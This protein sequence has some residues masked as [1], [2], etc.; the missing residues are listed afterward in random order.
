MLASCSS[1]GRAGEAD[2]RGLGQGVPHVARIPVDEVVL[3][4]VRLVGDDDDVAAVRKQ[5]VPV[6]PFFGEELL[7]GGEYH[8]AGFNRKFVAQVGPARRLYGWL[9]Q[10]IGTP[11]ESGEKLVVEIVAV[12][13]HDDGWVSHRKFT[14]DAPSVEGHREALSRSLGVPDDTD[15]PVTRCSARFQA[16]FVA[17]LF[18]A[19][20][21]LRHLPQFGSAKGFAHGGPDCV[22]LVIPRHLL[23]EMAAAVVLEDDEIPDQRKEPL[24]LEHA[25]DQHLEFRIEHRGQFLAADRSPGLEPFSSGGQRSDPRFESVRN[26]EHRIA[27]EQRG[28]FGLVGLK[29]LQGGPYRGVFVRCVLEFDQSQRKTVDEHHDVRAAGM[30]VFDNGELVHRQ[31]V[32]VFRVHRSR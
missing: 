10:Q 3:A 19:R 29:L 23:G 28:Q 15:T 6:A 32:V 8:A 14:D 9:S 7:D 21:L 27:C 13:Q 30:P 16:R 25:L 17:S 1:I 4:A 20:H 12:R 18:L 5:R 11:R 26:G 24:F 22:K 31:P 2:E